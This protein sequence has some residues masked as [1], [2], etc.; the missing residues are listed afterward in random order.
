MSIKNWSLPSTCKLEG[1]HQEAMQAGCC[2]IVFGTR[3]AATYVSRVKY[4]APFWH[5]LSLSEAQRYASGNS[6]SIR[7]LPPATSAPLGPY[8]Q[9]P[10]TRAL[11]AVSAAYLRL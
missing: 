5:W 7:R 11:E 8:R 2:D 10:P 3:G 6:S 9:A 1:S 4:F